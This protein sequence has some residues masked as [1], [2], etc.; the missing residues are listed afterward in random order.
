MSEVVD[1]STVKIIT[2]N[3]PFNMQD[4]KVTQAEWV[5]TK[6]LRE[7]IPVVI[8]GESPLEFVCSVNGKV[9]LEAEWDNT[10]LMDGDNVILCPVVGKSGKSIFRV[11]ALIAV[12]IIAP[13]VGA[14]MAQGLGW[15]AGGSLGVSLFGST[16]AAGQFL[17]TVVSFV[18]S[19]LVNS[20]LPNKPQN[21]DKNRAGSDLS[22]S[23]SYGY[24]GP[25]NASAEG[26]PVPVH[27]G[28]FRSGGNLINAYAQNANTTQQDLYMLFAVSEGP[29]AGVSDVY[30]NEQPLS[31]YDGVEIQT[32]NGGPEQAPINWFADTRTPR[33]LGLKV[34]P[35]WNYFT[36]IN[37]IDAFTL[38]L[39]FGAGLFAIDPEEGHTLGRTVE[40][41]VQARL[42]GTQNAWQA[43]G[44]NTVIE[45]YERWYTLNGSDTEVKTLPTGYMD[46][47]AIIDAYKAS[48]TGTLTGW[49]AI[50]QLQPVRIPLDPND[51]TFNL[52]IG[53]MTGYSSDIVQ[54]NVVY[55][56]TPVLVYGS[57]VWTPT[58]TKYKYTPVG[59]AR[60]QPIYKAISSFTAATRTALRYTIRSPQLAEGKYEIRY[61]RTIAESTE[62]TVSD[63]MVATEINEIITDDVAYR[64]T[65]VVGVK[66]RMSDQLSGLP[67]VTFKVA[68]VF[69]KVFNPDTETWTVE[70]T[71]NPAWIVY[72]MLTNQRYGAGLPE[73]R[74]DLRK[75]REWASHCEQFN[76]TFDGVF[77]TSLSLWDALQYVLRCG[78]A[79]IVNSGTRYTVAIERAQPATMMFS[80]ANMVE[81]TFQIDWLPQTDRANEIDVSYFD[82][83]DGYKQ[84]TL[85]VVDQ[86]AQANG[87]PIRNAS[88]SLFGVTNIQRA[89]N[90]GL[91]Q[92]ALNRYI[93]QTVTFD[94]AIEAIACTVG[95]VIY[96]QH[97]MPQWGFAGRLEDGSTTGLVQLD[98]PVTIEAD[99]SYRLLVVY[100]ALLRSSGT[101]YNII[102]NSVYLTGF[103]GSTAIKRLT[104]V[105]NNLIDY[106]EEADN[107]YW[108]KAATAIVKNA[109][110]AP[111][112]TLTAEGVVA[113][114]G[115]GAAIAHY[116][117]KNVLGLKAGF[118]YN[119]S[120]HMH[121]GA[122]RNLALYVYGTG[123]ALLRVFVDTVTKQVSALKNDGT[124]YLEN[125]GAVEMED[126]WWRV[127]VSGYPDLAATNRR[128]R[129]TLFNDANSG[130][131]VGDGTT[132][133]TYVWGAMISEGM[134]LQPYETSVDRKVMSVFDAGSGNYGVVVE[135]STGLKT[136]QSYRLYD[137]DVLVER[138][139][140]NSGQGETQAVPVASPFP[141]VPEQ[142]QH[143]MFGE[144]TKMKKPFRVRSIS[145]SGEYKRT[146]VALEYNE[147]VYNPDATTIVETP[148]YSALS[149]PPVGHVTI[150]GIEEN[151]YPLGN[152][153][154]VRVTI[155][156]GS[157][158]ESYKGANVL[159]S[160]NG[161][162]FETVGTDP[163]SRTVEGSEGD[164]L[165][166]KVVAFNISGQSAADSTA[167]VIEHVVMGKRNPPSTVQ[168][169]KVVLNP[170]DMTLSWDAVSDLDLS[171][172]EIRKGTSWDDG[173]VLVTGLKSTSFY[174]DTDVPGTF[175]YY[176]RAIDSTGNYSAVSAIA[177]IDIPTPEPVTGL[178]A[179]QNGSR[180]EFRWNAN[181]EPEITEYELREGSSWGTSAIVS[182]LK[183]TSYS[184]PAGS[185]GIR[186]FWIKAI[187]A[188]GVYSAV[189]T[190]AT[191]EIAPISDR[192]LIVTRDEGALEFPGVKHF[193]EYQTGTGLVMQEGQS[194]AEYIFNLDLGAQ[195]RAQNTLFSGL[196]SVRIDNLTWNDANF[197]WNSPSANRSFLG[198]GDVNSVSVRYELAK[199]T[200]LGVG[201]LEAWRLNGDVSGISGTTP[202]ATATGISYGL[203]RYGQGLYVQ[204]TTFVNWSIAVPKVFRK[205]FWL[206]PKQVNDA[207]YWTASGAG[208]QL[209]LKYNLAEKAFALE[210][211]MTRKV[212]LPFE[213]FEE[214]RLFVAI[215]QTATE[216]KLFVGRMN[217][218]VAVTASRPYAANDSD[219]SMLAMH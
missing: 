78:H 160:R 64:N 192:N 181:P 199:Y 164:I 171:G 156:Y 189:P 101:I 139:V 47:R 98:R 30:I 155:R 165:Q 184:M 134:A 38:E 180:L 198:S 34:T 102:G 62:S 210:D 6:P 28:I 137:T 202:A 212:T 203:G 145:G 36:T 106:A 23:P 140:V 93:L 170:T 89:Y 46:G 125:Y 219:Y 85:K 73:S 214:D 175:K 128:F 218:G 15:G 129:V 126:G 187:R 8:D 80:V 60:D 136:G 188:P 197:A 110:I 204:D 166:F 176:I 178:F 16:F 182:K 41:Q 20:L 163:Y 83:L 162:S 185:A 211:E 150:V 179:I 71:N 116:Y 108:G 119:Y 79:Q 115:S 96:V 31:N 14:M 143:F 177:V 56:A 82:A 88:V 195:Y 44:N 169:F 1:N 86:E 130:N 43:F 123:N 17:G 13:H 51:P 114:V 159:V 18:G 132:I 25:K 107:A 97:D 42:A 53:G 217:D 152:S 61:R 205:V 77:D 37:E 117:D 92:L 10:Y 3:S 190:F 55:K 7:Y 65:A 215:V 29:I 122:S 209:Q 100:D 58:Q 39:Y 5:A 146:I 161:G 52:S 63:S 194:R 68:G 54:E 94:A 131:F 207:V 142:Y 67:K 173:E 158:Q 153:F 208:K 168:N 149:T 69:I 105:K 103:D 19:Q 91:L 213:I 9:V 138:D 151:L 49:S 2:L 144:N 200:G 135:D 127:W 24:D 109:R 81:N 12:S 90:E 99:K 193:A 40:V 87:A 22:A 50:N 112:G 45:R 57:S 27:Y 118:I 148:N 216:R 196:G 111:N 206:I 157:D 84:H 21:S 121:P 147:S 70:A 104:A 191:T 95:D 59:T 4:F 76:L 75:F 11:I 186:T 167:P 35:D 172:Y 32:R 48:Q 113:S 141:S 74:I 133:H 154:G 72:D 201:E 33:N 124:G 66:V 174:D 183:A 26:V 120:I